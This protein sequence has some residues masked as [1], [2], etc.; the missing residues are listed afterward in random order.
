MEESPLPSGPPP[1]VATRVFWF[2]GGIIA[3][4]IGALITLGIG[5]VGAVAIGVTAVVLKRKNRRLTRRGAWFTSVGWTVGV[6]A[7]LFGFAVLT[8]DTKTPTAAERAEQRA[9]ATQAMP[10]WMKVVNPNAQKQTQAADS[11]AASLLSNKAVVV[12]AGLMGA[13]IGAGLM[14]TIAGSFVWGGTLLLQ[15]SW[16]RESGVVNRES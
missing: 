14:G 15:R 9:R 13:V 3:L 6:L 11:I 7:V 1:S 10:D 8:N 5:L 2:V 16:G 12:W 4:A